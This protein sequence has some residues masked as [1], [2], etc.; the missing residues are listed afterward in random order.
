MPH[1]IDP[2]LESLHRSALAVASSCAMS[3]AYGYA[4]IMAY[5][6]ALAILATHHRE[7]QP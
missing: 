6:A 1:D 4:A 7:V 5:R 3:R 2:R